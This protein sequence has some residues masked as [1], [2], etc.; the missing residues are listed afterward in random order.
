MPKCFNLF[1]FSTEGTI[2]TELDKVVLNSID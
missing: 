2:F 1:H